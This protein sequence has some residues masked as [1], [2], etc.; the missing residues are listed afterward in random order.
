MCGVALGSDGGGSVRYPSALT[1][2]F[3]IKPQRDRIPLD[4]HHQDAWNGLTAY[5][6]LARTV[7][8]AALFLEV[9][10]DDVPDGGF[11]AALERPPPSLRIAVSFEPPRGSFARLTDER[12]RAVE[13]TAQL[14]RSM[15]HDVF[16][17]QIDYGFDIMW[18]ASVR[19]IK[20]LEEDV[21]TMARP[22]RLE[23]NTQR[24]ARLG[25]RLPD[26]WLANA[27]TRERGIRDRMNRSFDW[28]DMVLTP[29]AGGPP[30]LNT[31]VAGH[32]LAR[33]LHKS[34]ASAWAVP[35][36]VI[37]QPAASVPIGVDSS[38]LPM[39]A[40]LCGRAHDEALL[41]RV[42]AQLEEARPWAGRRP[43]PDERA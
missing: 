23:R 40:Q 32:G 30:P 10:A 7:R 1:G 31:Q 14:L 28:A 37:G 19:Y 16:D 11:V 2:L 13:Q 15:G 5:G 34:N 20:G 41:L 22:H 36:N 4:P 21:A 38:G 25:G 24:L 6:P 29:I 8:D 9:T 12:R 39:A 26:R 18:N 17:Q 35:W 43:W 3:G 42:A 27:R 33:G